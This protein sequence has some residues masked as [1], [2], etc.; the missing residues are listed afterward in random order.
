M[1]PASW[2]SSLTLN[3][4]RNQDKRLFL[5]RACLVGIGSDLRGDDSAGLMVVRQ[6]LKHP[7]TENLLIIE[8]G[9]APENVTGQIRAFHPELVILIDAA[10]MDH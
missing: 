8:G 9:P 5:P 7:H 1:S 3:L 2:T 10:H 4:P 6:L